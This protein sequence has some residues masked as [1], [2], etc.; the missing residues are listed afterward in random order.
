MRKL[1][2]SIKDIQL[3][4]Q[5]S[6]SEVILDILERKVENIDSEVALLGD[7]KNIILEFMEQIKQVDEGNISKTD[8]LLDVADK[9]KK[10]PEVRIIQINPFKAFSSGADMIENVLGPFQQWQEAHNH[11]VK[12]MI[13]GVS[14]CRCT[15]R[16]NMITFQIRQEKRGQL[17][18]ICSIL[19][20]VSSPAAL[21]KKMYSLQIRQKSNK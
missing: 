12:K 17:H 1:N 13:Y 4:F 21:L 5:A 18:G 3:T 14:D 11:L 8:R 6:G 2:I 7:L 16:M 15:K 20:S 10:S 19:C 9:L